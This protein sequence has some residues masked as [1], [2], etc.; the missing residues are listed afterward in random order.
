MIENLIVSISNFSCVYPLYLCYKNKDIW[1][2]LAIGFVSTFSILS[3]LVEN[4]K[5]GMI[6]IGG[7]SKETS[8]ILNRF[9]VLG[10]GISMVRFGYLYYKKFGWNL[11]PLFS[12]KYLVELA[13]ISFFFLRISEYDKY[14]PRLK[15]RYII[16]HCIWHIGIFIAM[17]DFLKKLIY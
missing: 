4:H 8:Y 2:G 15:N 14:N 13:I 9:D 5:H 17:G 1:S 3:H 16:T 6:G 12:D 10:C 11:Y 7:F